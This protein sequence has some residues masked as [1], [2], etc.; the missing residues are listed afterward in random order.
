MLG[1]L[2]ATLYFQANNNAQLIEYVSYGNT[3]I[4]GFICMCLG[5]R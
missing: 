4:L 3:V 1:V 5:D 2:P